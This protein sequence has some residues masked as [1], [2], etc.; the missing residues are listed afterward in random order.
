MVLDIDLAPTFLDLAGIPIP[1]HMQGK[2]V[3]PLARSKDPNFRKEWLY[4]YFE[5]PN[6][7][8]VAVHRGIRTDRF[9]LIHYYKDVPEAFELYDLSTDPNETQNLYGRPE[10]ATVQEH[11]RNR[12]ESLRAAVPDRQ[13]SQSS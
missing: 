3:L 11:L 2:S 9:K 10:H 12:L 7:E 5:Y 1:P 4:E 13:G 8:N 6:P